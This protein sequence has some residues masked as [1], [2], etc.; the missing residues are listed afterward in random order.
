MKLIINS[1]MSRIFRSF[2]KVIVLNY[3]VV[4]NGFILHMMFSLIVIPI[5]F[6]YDFDFM[7]HFIHPFFKYQKG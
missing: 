1:D 4:I 5:D 2:N 6:I 7:F 3:K